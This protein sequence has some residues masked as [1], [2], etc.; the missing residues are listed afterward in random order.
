MYNADRFSSIREAVCTCVDWWDA[1]F[2]SVSNFRS[3]MDRPDGSRNRG[4]LLGGFTAERV[5]A[6]HND[7]L[8]KWSS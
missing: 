1:S 4:G 5:G 3:V 6:R 7:S 2:Q 8:D